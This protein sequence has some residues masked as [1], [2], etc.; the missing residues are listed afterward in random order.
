MRA[1]S[2]SASAS[3]SASGLALLA[4][5]ALAGA[6]GKGKSEP[7]GDQKAPPSGSADGSG[8]AAPPAPPVPAVVT[9]PPA[10]ALP[11][12]PAGLPEPPPPPAPITPEAVALGAFLFE[13]QALA[14]D[15][16]T[17]CASCHLPEAGYSGGRPPTALGRPNLRRAPPLV[18]AAW[19]RELGWDG[20]FASLEEHLPAHLHGQLGR[21]PAEAL[22]ALAAD[23]EA[24]PT[25]AA[26]FARA[27]ARPPTGERAA[28]AAVA[29]LAAFVR[30]RY[31]GG[32]R[33]DAEERLA[34]EETTGEGRTL[35]AGYALF[36][37]KARCSVCHPPPLYT[38]LGYH[39]LGLI[40]SA[41]EGRGRAEGAPPEMRGAFKTPTLRAAAYRPRFFH[42]A[43]VTTLP[44]AADWHLAGGVGQGADRSIVDPALAPVE[45]TPGERGQLLAFLAALS[46]PAQPQQ[47]PPAPPIHPTR[48]PQ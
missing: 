39:R 43:S 4:A 8:S 10:P 33:W 22:A 25:L 17:S 11:S 40:T 24:G 36:L 2:A 46:Q 13:A 16:K 47:S 48:P 30:T 37:G 15:G 27:F 5:L 20:R 29:A 44:A 21:E 42:D 26:H 41:D 32:S 19:Q 9:L 31:A 38:D 14:A 1:V 7:P 3:A 34:A 6:C 12:L 23:A 35:R 45:L 18:N 28:A